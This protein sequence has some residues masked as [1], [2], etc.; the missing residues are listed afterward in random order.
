VKERLGI[1]LG[2]ILRKKFRKINRDALV[3]LF[4]LFLSFTLWY[5]NY[6]EK[7]IEASVS[8]PVRYI[9]P[10]KERVLN[11][12][13]PDKLNIDLKGPGYSILKLKLAGNR[14]PVVVDLSRVSY[15]RL[16][17]SKPQRF[18][19]VTSGLMHT[20]AKQLRADFEIS[21]VKPDTIFFVFDRIISKKVPVKPVVEVVTERQYFVKGRITTD[22]DSVTITGPRQLTDTIA[23]VKTLKKKFRGLNE[24]L[25]K[26]IP[27]LQS[28]DYSISDR[29]VTVNI[30][31]EQFTEAEISVP[32]RIINVPDSIDIKIFPD[33][34]TVKC[35]VALSDY[36]KIK[37]VPFDVILDIKKT[38]FKGAEKLPVE[39][40]NI[41]PYINSLRFTP[42]MV[43]F[44]I[45]RK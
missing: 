3:F 8:Y 38:P 12:G 11:E 45:E 30:P 36:K 25:R 20:F 28:K 16:P 6:L 41:P 31:V 14:A 35:L 32:V 43:D 39:V 9:N 27:L 33:V 18:Y 29:R 15:R 24:T 37:E 44:I 22:P 23:E 1:W 19:L 26:S 7:V 4:F 5:L 10:P 21:S 40:L 13:L 17:E 42:G 2:N 34:V